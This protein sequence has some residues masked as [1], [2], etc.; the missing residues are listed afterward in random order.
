VLITGSS[1][2]ETTTPLPGALLDR[3]RRNSHIREMNGEDDRRARSDDSLVD[4]ECER[5]P[6]L[7]RVCLLRPARS[8]FSCQSAESS[9]RRRG[10]AS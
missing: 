9:S 6:I 5:K 2:S 3:L 10:A 1:I 7:F 8:G 4:A